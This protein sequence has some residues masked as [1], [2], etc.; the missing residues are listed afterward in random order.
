M[1]MI[2][3]PFPCAF[4]LGLSSTLSTLKERKGSKIRE[5]GRRYLSS[6]D[7]RIQ[8]LMAGI[9]GGMVRSMR[10][11]VRNGVSWKNANADRP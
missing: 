9:R 11:A 10:D 4:S 2:I 7:V 3:L 6:P 5:P 8:V 1:R